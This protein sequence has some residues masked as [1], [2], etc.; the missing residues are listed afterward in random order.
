M[1]RGRREGSGAEQGE[2]WPGTPGRVPGARWAEPGLEVGGLC[3]PG[4]G[5]GFARGGGVWTL[6]KARGG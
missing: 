5:P 4:N 1:G 3:K 2:G 6:P